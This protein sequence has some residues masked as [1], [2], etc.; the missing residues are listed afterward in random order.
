MSPSLI[1][2]CVAAYSILLFVVVWYTSRNADNES[3]FI[4]NKSS[5]WYIVAYGMIGASL[6]GVTFM[7]VPGWVGTTQFS[8]MMV[9]FGY[10]FGY[11]VIAM[12]LLPLYYRM[13]LTSI[14]TYLDERFGTRSYK[15]GAFYFILS[16][17]I[18]AAFRLYIVV[19]VLQTFVLDA[20][21]VPFWLTVACFIGLILLYTY[22]GGVKTIVW[23]DTLQTTFM[24]FAVVLSVFMIAR[25][26]NF[27][28]GNIL[29]EVFDGKYSRLVNTEWQERSF[30]LKQFLGG[31]FIAI[32]MT[33]L[34]QEMMQKNISV[35]N[36][37]DS[38]KNMFSFS[39]VLVFINFVF[40][41]LGVLLYLFA[42]AKGISFHG[43]TTDDLFPEI[44]LNYLGSFSAVFFIIGLISAAY[45]S[46]DGALTALTSSFCIDFLNIKKKNWPEVKQRNVRYAVHISFAFVLLAVIVIFRM[47]NDDAVINKLF[48]VAGYTYGPLLGLYAFG[49]ISK[50]QVKDKWVPLICLLSPLLCYYINDH[51]VAWMNGYKFGFELLILNGML[52]YFGLYLIRKPKAL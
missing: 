28:F 16:R 7:S 35:S 14:Y 33:G 38:Q 41:A 36:V 46:A 52:T 2:A 26:L 47:I 20:W 31:M 9:V 12:I 5:K 37:K 43:R 29:T 48:T 18:G 25:E 11:A 32:A 24:L 17:T 45:P 50:T 49:L 19:N 13:N 6:S 15:T 44:A 42:E 27:S 1:M 34:D 3:F 39:I 10:F 40:L 8:Y 23:T 22:K 4:G 51:S 21:G 30:W